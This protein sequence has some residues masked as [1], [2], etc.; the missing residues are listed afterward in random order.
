MAY[1]AYPEL[2]LWRSRL[3]GSERR[4]LA[5]PP[6]EAFLPRWSPDGT[7]ILFTDLQIGKAPKIYVV[8]SEGGTPQEVMPEDKLNEMDPTWSP[9]G[10]SIVFSR[11]HLD[12]NPA[13][14]RVELKTHGISKVPDSDGLTSSRLSPDGRYVAALS[15]DWMK[16]ML[17][18]FKTGKWVELIVL[19]KGEI[20]YPNWSH[21]G[22]YVYVIDTS[23]GPVIERVS[24][25]DHKTERIVDLQGMQQPL[26][27]WMGLAA[28]DSPLLRRDASAHE[29]YVLD[30]ELP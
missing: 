7:Q 3:D 8:A 12:T 28:D 11:S 23:A 1:V 30:L 22:K 2:T 21:D 6:M 5:F 26:L 18:D 20:G 10:S 19:R 24:V 4:Q 25:A 13:I 9:D 17:Y 29:I 15:S 16:L 27:G 14:Y